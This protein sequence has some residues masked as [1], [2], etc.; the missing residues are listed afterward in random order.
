MNKAF[1]LACLAVACCVLA[2]SVACGGGPA[3]TNLAPLTAAQTPIPNAS[4]STTPPSAPAPAPPAPAPPNPPSPAAPSPPAP[5]PPTPAPPSPPSPP[6]QPPA[7]T[8]NGIPQFTH[9]VLVVEENHSSE[10]VIGNPVMPYLNRLA[11][12]NGLATQCYANTHPSI[13]NY[14]ML[15]AGQI[16][17]NDDSFTGTVSANN[18]VRILNANGKSWKSYAES[19]P[20]TGYLGGDIFPYI[21]R[22]N[23]FAFF[24]D[25]LTTA[26]A[27]RIVPSWQL[28]N[29][30]SSGQLPQFAFVA[31]N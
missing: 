4:T 23:P 25:V 12:Q 26:Q 9:V 18:L 19:L 16:I 10:R 14:F 7:P 17:T 2:V 22:H 5:P 6:P 24:S 1:V 29:D 30:I 11:D 20:S 15:T 8:P 3:A 27:S 21:K 31:P 13:G 28:A